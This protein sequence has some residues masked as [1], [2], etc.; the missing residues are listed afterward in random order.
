M[1]LT[2]G[3][4]DLWYWQVSRSWYGGCRHVQSFSGGGSRGLWQNWTYGF[5]DIIW[6]TTIR[7]R[8]P[9][10]PS[11]H[12][13]LSAIINIWTVYFGSNVMSCSLLYLTSHGWNLI[14]FSFHLFWRYLFSMFVIRSRTYEEASSI[15]SRSWVIIF[16]NSFLMS[17][18]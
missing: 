12:H 8:R 3:V 2:V 5:P 18:S 9:P 13:R 16:W 14:S 10:F 7:L 1:N 4:A 17:L 6:H 15:K 11:K